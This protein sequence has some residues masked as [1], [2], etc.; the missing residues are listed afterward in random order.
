M[1]ERWFTV[2]ADPS[3][4]SP[5]LDAAMAQIPEVV[6]AVWMRIIRDEGIVDQGGYLSA[7]EAQ[8]ALQWPYL[9]DS[10][11]AAVVNLAPQAD[12]IEEGRAGFHLPSRWSR[13]Q[14]NAEG[15]PYAVVR[16]RIPTP[17]ARGGVQHTPGL[18]ARYTQGRPG[19]LSASRGRVGAAMPPEVYE[20]A[21]ALGS[22]GR[23]GGFG[24]LYKQSK[25][26]EFYRQAFGEMPPELE[27][28]TG[29]TW[30]ASQ[31]EGM[32]RQTSPTPQGGVHTEYATFRTI[33]P[34][35][36]GWYIPPSPP[37]RVAERALEEA[38][39]VVEE[40]LAEAAAADALSALFP[41]D[42]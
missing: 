30:A 36:P 42:T 2:D 25:S 31:F 9:G 6:R 10:S 17:F 14:M 23:L 41:E 26:Y 27:G 40:L 24:E 12:W 13:W 20:R 37:R 22:G 16:F 8:E 4:P 33:R 32:V 7:L 5:A 15:E 11:A 38:A 28:V 18:A 29:Y 19:G 1:A 3:R 34:D 35:S 39:S 21:R